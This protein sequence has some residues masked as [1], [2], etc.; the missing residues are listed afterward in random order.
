ML[1]ETGITGFEAGKSVD[2]VPVHF[3]NEETNTVFLV[4]NKEFLNFD[5]R[6]LNHEGMVQMRVLEN[7]PS[8]PTIKW[9]SE[10]NYNPNKP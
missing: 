7:L 10:S 3:Y 2:G 9:T 8:K 4:F 5:G 1:A 6:T